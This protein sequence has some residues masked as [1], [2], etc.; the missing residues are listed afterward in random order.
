MIRIIKLRI[1]E[2]RLKKVMRDCLQPM[3]I[4]R[5]GVYKPY[6]SRRSR[7]GYRIAMFELLKL[8]KKKL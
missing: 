6:R 2:L 3:Y 1:S 7:E 8:N 5:N 4:N